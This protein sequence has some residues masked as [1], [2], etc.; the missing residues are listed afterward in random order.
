MKKELAKKR[1]RTDSPPNASFQ[2]YKRAL[3]SGKVEAQPDAPDNWNHGVSK[4]HLAGL[5]FVMTNAIDLKI[6]EG[7]FTDEMMD[8]YGP[9]V[10]RCKGGSIHSD[11]EEVD[12]DDGEAWELCGL[13]TILTNFERNGRSFSDVVAEEYKRFL[14]VKCVEHLTEAKSNTANIWAEKCLP[15]KIVDLFWHCH[16]LRPKKYFADC[17]ELC[18]E[19]IDHEPGYVIDGRL[20]TLQVKLDQLFSDDER[21]KQESKLEGLFGHRVAVGDMLFGDNFD[22]KNSVTAIWMDM[23]GANDCG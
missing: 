13:M 2:P 3:I 20:N 10:Y 11:S 12:D 15:S 7:D 1:M 6:I 21:E 16:M 8:K 5:K 9:K 22:L 17:M 23:H 18:G 14:L 4:T 19:L